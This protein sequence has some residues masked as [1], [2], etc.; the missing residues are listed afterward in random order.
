[1]TREELLRRLIA[2]DSRSEV[3]NRAIADFI[4]DYLDAPGVRIVRNQSPDGTKLNVVAARGPGR[5][6]RS[7]L[8]LSG[9]MDTVPF[10]EPDWS[11]DPLV[12]G[13]RDERYFGRG[14]CD[15][16]GFLALAVERFAKAS[17]ALEHPLVLLFTYD[18][19]L[20]TIGARHLVETWSSAEPLP[21]AAVIGEPTSL[22][23]VRMHKGHFKLRIVVLGRP[24][25]SAYPGSG[26]NAIEMAG[27]VIHQLSQLGREL[28]GETPPEAA[29]FGEIRHATIN[30][31]TIAGG[32][33][34]NVIPGR[35]VLEIG[36]RLLPGMTGADMSERVRRAVERAVGRGAYALEPINESPAMAT[37]EAAPIHGTLCA[38]AGQAGSRAVAFTTDGG[39]LGK[40]GLDCVVF[41]PGSIQAAHKPDEW[42]AVAE[43]ERAAGLLESA[44]ERW[45]V[46]PG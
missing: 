24:G 46:R 11:T 27:G 35:C 23:V 18:E 25:H 28:E 36:I 22:E 3:S 17:A 42:L 41:G 21:Q 16:K 4:C 14:V 10:G 43:F 5:E 32:T 20:G 44:V 2:I 26:R 33:A 7:G 1:M 45:C 37:P 39:W 34:L 19:E 9:H 30:L 12:L 29:L 6:D 8:V 31:A 13:R 38:L 40:L 15:M